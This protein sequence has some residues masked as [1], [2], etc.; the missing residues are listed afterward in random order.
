MLLFLVKNFK[1]LLQK[2]LGIEVLPVFAP[3]KE[4]SFE[5]QGL[6]AVEK[7]FNKNA[8]GTTPG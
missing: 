3:S 6:T 8:V 2:L 1:H 7:I 4:I 5:G